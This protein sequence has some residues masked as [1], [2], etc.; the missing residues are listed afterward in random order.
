MSVI[1]IAG[2]SRSGST[3]LSFYLNE[4]LGVHSVGEI[5]KNIEIQKDSNELQRYE[6]EERL[7]TC[8]KHYKECEFW[9]ELVEEFSDLPEKECFDLVQRK[10]QKKYQ[11]DLVLDTSKSIR[12]LQKFYSD[13]SKPKVIYIIRNSSAHSNSYMKYA[14]KWKKPWYKANHII[15]SYYWLFKNFQNLQ[16]LKNNNFQ[17]EVVFYEDL[18]FN[19]EKVS[20]KL[21]AFLLVNQRQKIAA[22]FHEIGGNEGFKQTKDQVIFDYKFINIYFPALI[23][24]LT[25]PV[26]MYN[27]WLYRKYGVR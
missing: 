19:K 2:L 20:E 9:A 27:T 17:Y 4:L 11:N 23:Q 16:K 7:C 10:I 18:I 13:Q 6:R 12:R 24:L 5:I 25:I 1:Y 26:K 14:R 22:Q 21:S 8:G 15:F 3:Y